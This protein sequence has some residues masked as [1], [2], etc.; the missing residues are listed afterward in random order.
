MTE[1]LAILVAEDD[2][3]IQ[4]ML[5]DALT[6][7]GFRPQVLSSAEEAAT[8]LKSSLYEFRAL[9]TDVN[10]KGAMS[11]WD[12]ARIVRERDPD[13][14]VVYMTGTAVDDWAR[15][16]VPKS[17]LLSKPFAPPSSLPRCLSFS[18]PGGPEYKSPS[19]GYR[20][21]VWNPP[22]RAGRENLAQ[23]RNGSLRL[24]REGPKAGF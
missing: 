8:V 19:T 21:S 13:F 3:Q 14:P 7:G 2:P 1:S 15:F 24:R 16:G 6:E 11:G 23:V 20:I 22:I 17:I 4:E 18:T 10:L 12:L 9:V 5:E